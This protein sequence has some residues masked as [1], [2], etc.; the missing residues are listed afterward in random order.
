MSDNQVIMSSPKI[1][2]DSHYC[3][4]IGIQNKYEIIQILAEFVFML[5]LMSEK[6]FEGHTLRV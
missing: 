2:I 1:V 3:N 4:T 5:G 6:A